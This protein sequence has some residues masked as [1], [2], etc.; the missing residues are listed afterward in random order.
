MADAGAHT[1]KPVLGGDRRG[2]ERRETDVPFTGGD[3]RAGERRSGSDRRA[4][5]RLPLNP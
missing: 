3:R 5:A 1:P 4:T 2:T